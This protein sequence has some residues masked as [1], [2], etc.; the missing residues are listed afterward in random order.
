MK[1]TGRV[2]LVAGATRGAGRGI[3]VSLAEAGATVYCTGRSTRADADRGRQKGGPFE[4]ARR[5]E[6]IEETAELAAARG[7]KAIAV[8]ADHTDPAQVEA[9][10]ARIKAEQGRLD[11]LVNDVWGGDEHTEW[12]GAGLG[13]RAGARRGVRLAL[14]ALLAAPRRS[15]GE[16]ERRG[17]LRPFGRLPAQRLPGGHHQ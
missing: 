2:A 9:L 3:A 4:L 5:P 11:V 13:A 12:G 10:V 6:T 15:G 1:L 17:G 16:A 7:G 14:P 8:R